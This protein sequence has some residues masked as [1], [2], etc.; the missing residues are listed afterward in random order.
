MAKRHNGDPKLVARFGRLDAA[1]IH[2]LLENEIYTGTL[3]FGKTATDVIDDRRVIQQ[4]PEERWTRVPGF[5]AALVARQVFDAVAHQRRQRGEAMRAARQRK[6][7]GA[8]KLIKPVSA[9]L[10]LKYPLTGLVRC[11][12]CGGSMRPNSSGRT[13]KIGRRYTYYRCPGFLCGRCGNDVSV[14]EDWLRSAV[15]AKVRTRLFPPPARQGRDSAPG[16]EVPAWLPELMDEVQRYWADLRSTD[17]D[18]RPALQK[19]RDRLMEDMSGWTQSL[20]KPGLPHTVRSH[21]EAHLEDAQARVQETNQELLA[22]A[23][24]EQQ[25]AQLLD[26]QAVVDCLGRLECALGLTNP[27]TLNVELSQHIDRIEVHRDRRIVLRTCRLGIFEGVEVLISGSNGQDRRADQNG[28]S[29]RGTLDVVT[30]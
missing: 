4:L 3:V 14:P 23:G 8:D 13:S 19:E 9:G 11:G 17:Y 30:P 1:T 29:K 25:L 6:Q 20:A 15:I 16:L 10:S 12:D 2:R 22:I 18:Q 7:Q 24:Q 26:L 28:D 21:L 27:T 5:C